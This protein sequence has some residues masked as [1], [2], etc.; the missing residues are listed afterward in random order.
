MGRLSSDDE[1]RPRP[2]PHQSMGIMTPAK[3]KVKEVVAI[4][5]I[6]WRACDKCGYSKVDGLAIARARYQ[7]EVPGGDLYFCGHCFRKYSTKFISE[8]YPIHDIQEKV[9][10]G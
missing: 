7:I 3:Q 5:K 2:Q 1:K 6:V 4:V 8:G 10:A 9:A